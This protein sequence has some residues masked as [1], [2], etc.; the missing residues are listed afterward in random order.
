MSRWSAVI[1]RWS[2][3]V[4]ALI[5]RALAAPAKAWAVARPLLRPGGFLL[6]FAGRDTRVAGPFPGGEGR[7]D[8]A[9]PGPPAG[10]RDPPEWLESAGP[11]VMITRT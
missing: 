10:D 2:L 11:L 3:V 8:P 4:P 5:A 6:L 1:G 9:S 7:V